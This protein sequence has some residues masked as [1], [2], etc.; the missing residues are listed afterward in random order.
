MVPPGMS[1]NALHDKALAA[2]KGSQLTKSF[3]AW[4]DMLNM[5]KIGFFPYTP[6]TQMLHRLAE[7]RRHAARGRA[8]QRVRPPRPTTPRRPARAVRT[9]GLEGHVPAI[10]NTTRR[11]SRR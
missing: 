8:R 6:A 11:R 3:W 10:R 4:D 2:G 7:G 1:L 5:N 9:W